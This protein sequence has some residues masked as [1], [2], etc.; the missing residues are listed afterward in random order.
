MISRQ[1]RSGR[2]RRRL[3]IAAIVLGLGSISLPV[4]LA[5]VPTAA[6]AARIDSVQ[7]EVASSGSLPP[8]VAARMR[9][10][11]AAIAGQLLEGRPVAD[12]APDGREAQTIREV[13]DKVLVGYS[14]T[15][16]SIDP[17]PA[18]V[19]RVN[20]QPWSDV[21]S[22]VR[23]D[24]SVEGMP[25]RV[26]ALVRS[27]LAQV[28]TVFDEALIG[29]PVAASD[30]TNGVL[31]HHLDD[32]MQQHLPEFRADFELDPDV[33]AHVKLTVYP[34]LPVVRTIDLSMRSDT[35]PNMALLAYRE[36]MQDQVNDLVGVPV[37]FV[38]RHQEIFERQFADG[39]DRKKDF[40]NFHMQT[41]VDITPSENLH[42]MSRSD[43]TRFRL[44]LT[45]WMDMGRNS[46]HSY[47][48]DDNLTMRVESGVMLSQQDELFALLD[49]M[50]QEPDWD[51][52]LGFQ[53][54]LDHW[55]WLH[56]R[57]D[58]RD[59]RFIYGFRHMLASHWS[60]RYEYRRADHLGEFGL[61]YR[62]HDFIG[63]EYV[64]DR[65]QGWMR[66]LGF[67]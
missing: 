11:V 4:P 19:V 1:G 31:K 53:H 16:V 2:L 30:W 47:D 41:R 24:T 42:V 12:I 64:R 34:R 38:K 27:D 13:F 25:P 57:Y 39:L 8:L 23:V 58:M 43:T 44:R 22:S 18:T 52:Q 35:V 3:C 14:V 15:A 66:V 6:A 21:I 20:L 46:G 65:E 7:A 36:D 33:Q 61:L 60:L 55:D 45:G 56:L 49:F 32:Y 59:K 51:W 29:L 9:D 28:E 67:F 37:A 5:T 62:P 10:S 54:Q 17:G 26:E 40:R 63:I 48:S 50:P